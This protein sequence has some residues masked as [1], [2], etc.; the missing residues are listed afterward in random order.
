MPESVSSW[1]RWSCRW[2]WAS[3]ESLHL[4]VALEATEPLFCVEA[5]E[6]IPLRDEEHGHSQGGAA[7]RLNRLELDKEEAWAGQPEQ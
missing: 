2:A 6:E 7:T 1:H 3:T 5:F 4:S